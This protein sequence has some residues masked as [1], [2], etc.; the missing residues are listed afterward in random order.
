MILNFKKLFRQLIILVCLLIC[1]YEIWECIKKL[2]KNPTTTII[3][4]EE[5]GKHGAPSITICAYS[6]H[7]ENGT[8]FKTDQMAENGLTLNDY[9]RNNTWWSN[10]S[11]ISP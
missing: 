4:S 9:V 10:S 6:N 7:L 1:L 3:Y 11:D 5:F 8:S 2:K